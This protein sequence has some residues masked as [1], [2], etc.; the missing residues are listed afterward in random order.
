ME[1]QIDREKYDACELSDKLKQGL[2]D[3]IE[4]AFLSQKLA[5]IV[6][7]LDI[8]LEP[9]TLSKEMFTD[10]SVLDFLKEYEFRSLLPKGY[11][12]VKK[13]LEKGKVIEVKDLKILDEVLALIKKEQK[14]LI[15]TSKE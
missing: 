6:T 2:L 3:N 7:D 4:N 13:S 10:S 11:V 15:A 5:T 1:I 12:E 8:V 14:V 9:K